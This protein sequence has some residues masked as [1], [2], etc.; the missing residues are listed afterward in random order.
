[1]LN[2][3][4]TTTDPSTGPIDARKSV[5]QNIAVLIPAYNPDS[6]L[7]EFVA[8]LLDRGFGAILVVNDGSD[9]RWEGMFQ[10]IAA[11][12]GCTVI[13][14]AVNLGKGRA[15]KSGLNH[16]LLHYPDFVGIVTADADGQH[17]P[18]DAVS[19]A[20]QLASNPKHLILGVRRFDKGMPLR[21]RL[22]NVITRWL[23]TLLIGK[24]ISDT[25]SGLR[26]L[27]RNFCVRGLHVDGE[28]YEYEMNVLIAA[29]TQAR[30][31][32]E[33]PIET[34]YIGGNES[35][36]FN[37]LIDSLKIYF[38]LFRFL[39]SSILASVTDLVI[40]TITYQNTGNLT[41]SL[42]LGRVVIGSLVN[43]GLNR[44][45]VFHSHAGIFGPLVK[46]YILFSINALV[47]YLC[48]RSLNSRYGINIVSAKVMVESLLFFASFAIQR[49]IV[50]SSPPDGD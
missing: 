27:S 8:Q 45:F 46:Y 11:T 6:K 43:F 10:E 26:G 42:L 18:D 50:F 9:A 5:L 1:M 31:I 15:L 17:S 40:F 33:Q 49:A 47:S 23:F 22:G 36:H 3:E 29:R 28:H 19:V 7:S 16:F 35:S 2:Q 20:R 24:R 41:L 25:Q 44:S 4:L 21:S 34:I 14:H 48:I 39:L 37:P 38:V 32:M 13:L 30:G 12:P